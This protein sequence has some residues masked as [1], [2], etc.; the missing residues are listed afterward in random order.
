MHSF[1]IA[2]LICSATMSILA[3]MYMVATPFLAKRYSEKGR[4]YAWLIIIIGLIIPF[5]PQWNNSIVTMELPMQ[6]VTTVEQF[7]GGTLPLANDTATFIPMEDAVISY[8]GLGVSWSWWQI[9]FAVWLAGML[10]FVLYQGIRH[11]RFVKMAYRWRENI[12]NGQ[13]LSIFESLKSEMGITKRIC[14]YV[15]PLVGSPM[16]IGIFNPKI[17]LPTTELTEDELQFILKHELVHYKRKDLLYKFLVLFAMAMHWFNPIVYLSVKAINIL[18]ETSCDTEVVNGTDTNTRQ[19]YS[20][21]IVGVVKYQSTLKT[22]LSTNFYG[23]KKGM[24]TRISS[25]MDTGKK[26][27]GAI[28]MFVALMLT[29]GTNI[30]FATNATQPAFTVYEMPSRSEVRADSI[31]FNEAA[32]IVARHILEEYGVCINGSVV[33]VT[34]Q[35]V[36]SRMRSHVPEGTDGVWAVLVGESREAISRMH[37]SFIVSVDA[38]TGR[39]I[40]ESINVANT[41]LTPF[42]SAPTVTLT[43]FNQ[44]SSAFPAFPTRIALSLIRLCGLDELISSGAVFKMAACAETGESGIA[45]TSERATAQENHINFLCAETDE[46]VPVEIINVDGRTPQV[47]FFVEAAENGRSRMVIPSANHRLPHV[48]IGI[49]QSGNA[50]TSQNRRSSTVIFAEYEEWGLTIEGLSPHADGGFIATAIQNVFYQGQLVR[51]FSDF[52][53]GVDMS[54]SSFDQGKDIWV[55]VMRDDNGNIIELRLTQPQGN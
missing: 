51:G 33:H 29:L 55:Y 37:V 23:G 47:A 14:I 44:A 52:G 20:E 50:P 3:G 54:I 46:I 7:S 17:L 27:A 15:C 28:V 1:M 8:A 13:V 45:T 53:H 26:K 21:V 30:V 39:I 35:C 18:C 32:N 19:M 11:Y 2:L 41:V 16:L 24:K 25:I 5:R 31:T 9:S 43:P 36:E 12:I 49:H 38:I 10:L 42:Q 4:Y 48:I 22:A 6:T 34:H 40:G